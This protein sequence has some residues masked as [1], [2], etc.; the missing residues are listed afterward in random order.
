MVRPCRTKRNKIEV[1]AVLDLLPL[2]YNRKGIPFVE[3]AILAFHKVY[4]N[5]CRKNLIFLNTLIPEAD[6]V[7]VSTVDAFMEQAEGRSSCCNFQPNDGFISYL[8]QLLVH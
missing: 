2:E 4:T 6:Q 5:L 1:S 8:Q 3:I 7:H